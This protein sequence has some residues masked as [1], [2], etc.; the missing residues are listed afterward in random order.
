MLGVK[1]LAKIQER[2]LEYVHLKVHHKKKTVLQNKFIKILTYLQAPS[3]IPYHFQQSGRNQ[4]R[5][6]VIFHNNCL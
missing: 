6:V 2:K 5:V 1:F 3:K 4:L